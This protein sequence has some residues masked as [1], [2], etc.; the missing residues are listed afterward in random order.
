MDILCAI[1]LPGAFDI[2][3]RSQGLFDELLDPFLAISVTFDCLDDDAVRR[4]AGFA[5]AKGRQCV[6]TSQGIRRG[7][8]QSKGSVGFSGSHAPNC[9]A[10]AWA[11]AVVR[12][13]TS[14]FALICL[15]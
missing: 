1:N 14:N 6:P 2:C 5:A 10:M 9:I 4:S 15:L 11:S 8:I 12:P 13:A 7:A 3:L